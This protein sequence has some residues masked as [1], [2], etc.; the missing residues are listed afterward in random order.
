MGP[1]FVVHAALELPAPLDVP[2][3]VVVLELVPPPLPGRPVLPELPVV[4]PPSAETKG[5]M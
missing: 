5:G 1:V 3:T 4:F 2:P